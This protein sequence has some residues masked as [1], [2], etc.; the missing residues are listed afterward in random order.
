MNRLERATR[1]KKE[2]GRREGWKKGKTRLCVAVTGCLFSRSKDRKIKKVELENPRQK[3][4]RKEKKG[5][6]VKFL[7]V[8]EPEN[9]N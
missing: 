5:T 2:D 6:N 4:T 9:N 7:G 8:E 1:R 3:E